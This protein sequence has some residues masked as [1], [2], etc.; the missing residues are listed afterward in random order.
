MCLSSVR[1]W[2]KKAHAQR[3]GQGLVVLPICFR[4]AAET[5]GLLGFVVRGAEGHVLG[6]QSWRGAAQIA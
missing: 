2:Q 3:K 1:T 6:M 4:A 5:A